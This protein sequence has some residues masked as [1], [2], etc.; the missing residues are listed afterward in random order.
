MRRL[1]LSVFLMLAM[2]MPAAAQ[3]GKKV[4]VPAGTPE[5]M[6]TAAIYAEQDPAKKI[7]LLDQFAAQHPTGDFALLADQLYVSAY[8]AEKNYDKAFEYGEKALAIDPDNFDT[9]VNLVRAAQEDG[10]SVK[11]FHYGEVTGAI[12]ARYKASSAPAGTSASDWQATKAESLQEVQQDVQYVESVLLNAAYNTADP[13][14]KAQLFERFAAAF[15]DSPNAKTAEAESVLAYQAAR[16]N[17]KMIEAAQHALKDDPNNVTVLVTMAEYWCEQGKQLD[18]ADADAK[19]ALA[20]LAAEA[21]PEG[22]SDE[23]WQ[24]QISLQKGLALSAEGQVEV[25]RGQNATAIQAFEQAGPLLKPDNFSYGRNLYRWGYTLAK[26]RRIPEARRI[27]T[28]AV[29]TKSPYSSLAEQTLAQIGGPLR[30]SAK[31]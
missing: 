29:D 20:A 13:L 27:L 11:L 23:D 21:K 31:P 1:T 15:P 24:K 2:A 18:E 16:N 4:A 28:Q 14:A 22:V 17:T 8:S 25:I 12:L 3:I 26:M 10:D 19:K 30:S 9:A 5:D 6:A 7:A